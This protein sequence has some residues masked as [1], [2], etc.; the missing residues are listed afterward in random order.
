MDIILFFT[1]FTLLGILYTLIGLAASRNISTNTDYFLAGKDL[2][3]WQLVFTLLATQ[4]GGGMLLGTAQEAYNFGLYGFTYTIGMSLGFVLLGFGFAQKLQ[5]LN[6]STTAELFQTRYKSIILKKIASL[7]SIATMSGIVIGQIIGSK[8]LLL[9]LGLENE[10]LFIL[11]WVFTIWYTMA[12]GLKA[13]VWTDTVQIIFILVLFGGLFGYCLWM[14]P[15]SLQVLYN[16]PQNVFG[17]VELSGATLS[18]TLLMPL[19]FSLIEQ[20]LAQRFFAARTSEIAKLGSFLSAFGLLA[21]SAIPIYFGMQAKITGLMIPNNASP[22]I[23]Y[24]SSFTHDFI[25][26]LAACAIIAA[27]TS[28]ADSLLCAIGS[29]LGQDF[30][31]S[32]L[33]LNP[34]QRSRVITMLIGISTLSASYFVSPNIIGILISS[35]ELS[36][37]CLFIPLI[38]CYFSNNVRKNAAFGG[39]IGGFI[40]FIGFRIIPIIIPKEL[41]TLILSLIGYLLGHIFTFKQSSKSL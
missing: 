8:K 19:L 24:I 23:P 2:G 18:A 26:V 5:S 10:L 6:V 35:Y 15:S 9:S 25:L 7:L 4:I 32:Y 31:F 21:F 28:T 36:V 41:A 30:D 37:S 17:T 40:G 16:V 38:F 11:F 14:N 13:V 29:N 1:V 39:V 12:G 22:L 20:D 33:P 3:L 34:V 27:I